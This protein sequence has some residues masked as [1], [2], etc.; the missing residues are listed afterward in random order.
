[1]IWKR[2][3]FVFQIEFNPIHI[4]EMW[5]TTCYDDNVVVSHLCVT[6]KPQFYT[7]QNEQIK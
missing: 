4:V 1:M 3:G 6:Q 7:N 5:E 2:F